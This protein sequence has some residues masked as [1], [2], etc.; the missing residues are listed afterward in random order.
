L[1][2]SIDHFQRFNLRRYLTQ[3]YQSLDLALLIYTA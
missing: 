3:L 1:L 2:L